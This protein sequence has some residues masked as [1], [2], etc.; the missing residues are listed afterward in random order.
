MEAKSL[1]RGRATGLTIDLGTG[2]TTP[3]YRTWHR[4]CARHLGIS[5]E[6]SRWPVHQCTACQPY[7]GVG[8][9][10]GKRQQGA[11]HLTSIATTVK[12]KG[13]PGGEAALVTGR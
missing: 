11:R 13:R 2:L 10:H 7:C 12:K 8:L 5:S 3:W 4:A 1:A 9:E 6:R